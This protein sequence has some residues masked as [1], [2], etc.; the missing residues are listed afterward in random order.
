MRVVM[1]VSWL[2]ATAVTVLSGCAGL[3][4][5]PYV[6]TAALGATPRAGVT[7]SASV[8]SYAN[9]SVTS[10]TLVA[11]GA[12]EPAGSSGQ[13]VTNPE[14]CKVLGTLNPRTSAVDGRPYGIKF[15]MRFPTRWNGRFFHQPNGGLDGVVTPAVGDILGGGQATSGTTKGFV[16]LS[17]NAGHDGVTAQAGVDANIRGGVF[18]LDP[19]ARLDYGYNAV[20]QLTPMAK[21]LIKAYY[22]KGPD[23]SYIVGTS[24]GGRH[25]MVAASRFG[26]Q[27]DG[28][29]VGS[30]GFNLPKAALAQLWG[31]NQLKTIATPFTSGP[32]T[33]LPDVSTA[34]TTAR[35]LK[36]V[37]DTIVAKCDALDGVAD[38]MVNDLLACQSV[39]NVAT[40]IPTCTGAADGTCLTSGQKTVLANMHAGAK[41]TAGTALYT[42]FL[43]SEGI[44][45]A[46]WMGWKAGNATGP[47][48][49]LSVGFVFTTPPVSTAVLT[50]VGPSILNYVFGFNFDTDAPKIFAKDSVYTQSA[51][52]FMPPPD[53]SMAKMVAHHGKMILVHGAADPVFSV[54]DTIQWYQSFKTTHGASATDIARLFIVPGMGHSRGGLATD[55]Y[56]MVD[57]LVN[58]VEKGVPPE[59]VIATARGA[60]GNIV[61][62]TKPTTNA[63]IPSSWAANRT[64]PLCPYPAVARYKG[65]GDVEVASSFVCQ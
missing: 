43:W 48:D 14:Y 36:L 56:D 2:A 28:Y 34:F 40:D 41:N 58:W 29:L 23:K 20:A 7:C 45:S 39:F 64:R 1:N 59:S 10:A 11:A 62:A 37:S 32:K 52:E 42:N 51:M 8:F 61:S 15:E 55:H 49:P 21:S 22:G 4:S 19:Q 65:T 46:G 50:G 24:N 6:P 53:L 35:D 12:T 26:D 17:S 38:H 33:G 57:A 30:P 25:A 16:T 5:A 31:A 54:N 18:G 60:A 13:T 44:A 27:Y 47:R 9:L 63:E 3:S